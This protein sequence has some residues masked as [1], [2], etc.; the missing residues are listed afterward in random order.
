M[1]DMSN[2]MAS[3]SKGNC[4]NKNFVGGLFCSSFVDGKMEFCTDGVRA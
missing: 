3:L 2:G 1:V 4:S